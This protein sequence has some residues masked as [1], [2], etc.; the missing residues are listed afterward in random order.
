MITHVLETPD[1]AIARAFQGPADVTVDGVQYPAAIFGRW[2]AAELAAIRL[3]PVVREEVAFDPATQDAGEI[4]PPLKEDGRWIV[5]NA[6]VALSSETLDA[7]RAEGWRGVRVT[8]DALLA[9]TDALLLRH[10]DEKALV[11]TGLRTATTLNDSEVT[12]LLVYRQTLRDLPEAFG[13]P[14]GDPAA[15]EWPATPLTE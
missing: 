7:R 12:A 8:R 1:G 9:E 10:D 11:A 13:A 4:Q 15:V 6:P 5:R 2:T 3:Y 14:D